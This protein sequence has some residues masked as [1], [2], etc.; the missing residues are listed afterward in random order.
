MLIGCRFSM[1]LCFGV[2][3][4]LSAYSAENFRDQEDDRSGC[5]D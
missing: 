2:A 1:L 5:S 3:I 4:K